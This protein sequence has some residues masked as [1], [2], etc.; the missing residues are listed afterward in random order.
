MSTVERD[1]T[2]RSTGAAPHAVPAE[3][4]APPE[5]LPHRR[6]IF[7]IV[8]IALFMTSVDQTIVATALPAIEHDFRAHIN[9]SGW[10]I[11]IYAL[12]QV[13]AMPL[14]GKISDQFGRKK[15]FLI[16][17]VVFTLASL[18]CGFATNIETLVVLRAVQAIGGGAFMP[19]ATG[20]VSD[21]FGKDRDRALGMFASIFPIGGIVG[22][23]IGGAFV[24]AW[25]W[26]GIFLVNVPIG[27]ALIALA[28]IFI[29]TSRTRVTSRTDLRGVLLLGV[30]ILSAM[31]GITYL[32]SATTSLISPVFLV[33]EA[34]AVVAG[35]LFFRHANRYPTP[36]IPIRLLRGRGFG[37]MNL[38]NLLYGAAAL[39]FGALV[40][41]Y[42]EDRFG[43]KPLAAGTLLTARAVG[44][45]CVAAL[46]VAALRRTG[47]R[48]PM[49][50]GFI[51]VFVGLIVMSLTPRGLS[52]YLWLAVAAAVTGLGMGMSVPASNNASLQLAPDQVAAIAGLRG[53]FRQS[54]AIMAVSITT[55]VV[56][57]SAH[58]GIA[59]AHIFVIF[60]ILLIATLP[61][62]FLVP[63]HR[64]SW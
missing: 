49:I 10:T 60:A 6:L 25:S 19:S 43:I 33:S 17:A 7:A 11:T 16:S 51:T 40:P 52:P 24:A 61:L 41:L 56:A 35:W 45:I 27:I 46:A 42:A 31:F 34:I 62:V 15:V 29:P 30:L 4:D 44:M 1:T 8:S 13:L 63:D 21:H 5:A 59:Q 12:G 38:I 23:I 39:G 57:R 53:M 55:T 3:I 22:P 28:V 50:V 37:T 36:F 9:W 54:G 48:L 18:S 26:R 58:P 20:I 47:Y 32:G 64:G 2:P 14:A